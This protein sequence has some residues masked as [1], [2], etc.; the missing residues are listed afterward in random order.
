MTK[1]VFLVLVAAAASVGLNSAILT[2]SDDFS[3]KLPDFG[4]HKVLSEATEVPETAEAEPDLAAEAGL[5]GVGTGAQIFA[6]TPS[7]PVISAP[8]PLNYRVTTV[9]GSASEFISIHQ[10]LSYSQI[11]RFEKLIYGHN[12]ANLLGNLSTLTPGQIFT[13]T[14]GGTTTNYQVASVVYYQNTETGLN[15][16]P[17]LMTR[18]AYSALGYDTALMTCA[19]TPY[20]NG[21][22]TQ[23]LVVFANRV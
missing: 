7:T 15:G 20:G 4:H 19:G 18:I 14:E 1:Q 22:A 17:A 3:V 10:N 6:N 8:A 16:D 23:R 9:V 5:I 2:A 13:V 12:T 11:Y 21:N